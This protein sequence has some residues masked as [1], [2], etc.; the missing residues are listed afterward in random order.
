MAEELQGLRDQVAQLTAE[1][2]RLRSERAASGSSTG[3]RSS[4]GPAAP[5]TSVTDRLLYIPRDRKCPMF[6]GHTG[7]SLSEWLEEVEACMRARHLSQADQAY[8]MYDHLEGEARNEIRYRSNEERRDPDKLISILQ[9]LYGCTDSYVA[10]QEAFFSRKQQE[11]ETLQEFSLA[12]LSLMDKV[13]ARAPGNMSNSETLL[14][15]QFIE[16]VLD[17]ALR[18]ML[19]QH[20]RQNPTVTLLA[21]REE[22]M[23]WERE[24]LPA[25]VRGRSNSVPS[26]YGLQYAVHSGP[27][28]A[29]YP[30]Q[31]EVSEMKELLKRQQEQLDRLTQS[32]ALLQA[33]PS[34]SHSPRP[35]P[36]ICKRCHRPGHI[37]RECRGPRGPVRQ[38]PSLPEH[39]RLEQQSEN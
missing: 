18:R 37:A 34:R 38:Q 4:A 33:A 35:G 1:N 6:R 36:I 22:A 21:V 14:R 12:L 20:V 28:R 7:I 16:H 31:S 3:A 26:A 9:N 2:E 23:R 24:G 27:P 17:G 30:S 25:S 8:F 29:T 19:K 39:S 15:D 32:I 11:G 13:K 10:L 5:T